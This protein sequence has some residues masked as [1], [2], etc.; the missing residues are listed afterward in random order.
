MAKISKSK[1]LELIREADLK[2][3]AWHHNLTGNANRACKVCAVGAILRGV[4]WNFNIK[5]AWW[6]VITSTQLRKLS[7]GFENAARL[8]GLPAAKKFALEFVKKN[9]PKTL[10]IELD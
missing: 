2:A 6:P 4:K 8:Q 1:I 3:G 10:E 9:F 5:D 7:E